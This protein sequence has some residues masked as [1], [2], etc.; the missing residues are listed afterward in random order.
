MEHLTCLCK[1]YPLLPTGAV[2][3]HGREPASEATEPQR[4]WLLDP[5]TTSAAEG[6]STSGQLL[7]V[8]TLHQLAWKFS[9]SWAPNRARWGPCETK[10]HSNRPSE[11]VVACSITGVVLISQVPW[12]L[13]FLGRYVMASLSFK[14]FLSVNGLLSSF[15]HK[16]AS[17]SRALRKGRNLS[18]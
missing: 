18:L 17:K 7:P 11:A 12:I 1:S 15:Q 14:I 13:G 16:D 2:S 4:S 3:N 6:C 10:R 8:L 5:A 9:F